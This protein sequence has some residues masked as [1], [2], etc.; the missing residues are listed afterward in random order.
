M[1][2]HLREKKG[3]GRRGS[4]CEVEGTANRGAPGESL[5]VEYSRSHGLEEY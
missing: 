2:Q 5:T 4:W 3:G 1:M